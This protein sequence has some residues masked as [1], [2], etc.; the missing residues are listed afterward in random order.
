MEAVTAHHEVVE[1]LRMR[2]KARRA[3]TVPTSM[4]DLAARDLAAANAI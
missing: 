3:A 1:A 4:L 2:D